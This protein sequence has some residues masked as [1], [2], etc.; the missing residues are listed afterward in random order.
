LITQTIVL[1]RSDI[2]SS[3]ACSSREAASDLR[4]LVPA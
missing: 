3:L 4:A 2:T 1:S